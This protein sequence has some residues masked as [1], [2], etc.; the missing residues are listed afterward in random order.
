MADMRML[1]SSKPRLHFSAEGTQGTMVP[2]ASG[3]FLALRAY[4]A[5]SRTALPGTASPTVQD[6]DVRAFYQLMQ[7]A[8]EDRQRRRA[9]ATGPAAGDK[10][11]V[12]AHPKSQP[13]HSSARQTFNSASTRSHCPLPDLARVT[14]ASAASAGLAR[15]TCDTRRD[16]TPISESGSN[17]SLNTFLHLLSLA[18]SEETQASEITPE[19]PRQNARRPS[20]PLRPAHK[21]VIYE[22]GME[23]ATRE[24]LLN[25]H[26]PAQQKPH[27]PTGLLVPAESRRRSRS[28]ASRPE[29]RRVPSRQDLAPPRHAGSSLPLRRH[30]SD[31]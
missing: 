8:R 5:A 19:L 18:Q 15:C 22:C 6:D 7:R 31:V 16:S 14:R 21:I 27:N 25:A 30:V 12:D 24:W 9:E 10:V 4:A 20:K 11:K 13:P 2:T 3:D 29:M 28:H 26:D 23:K 17:E 1:R